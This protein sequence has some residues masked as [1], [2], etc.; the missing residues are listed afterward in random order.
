MNP[1]QKLLSFWKRTSPEIPQYDHSIHGDL[2][3][4]ELPEGFNEI[5]RYWIKEPYIFVYILNNTRT[6]EMVYYV[7]EPALSPYEIILLEKLHEDLMDILTEKEA[8]YEN[9]HKKYKLKE[10][11]IELLKQY[12][13]SLK[14]QTIYKIVYYLNRNL[15]GY[16]KIDALLND[17]QIEDISCDGT[18]IPIFLYHRKHG[19]IKTNILFDE[20]EL[21]SFVIK[22]CQKGGKHISLGSP[23]VNATLPNGSRLQ[24]TLGRD[25]TTR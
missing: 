11:A 22:I 14:E 1:V 23:L 20:I 19:N 5:E 10:Y 9:V 6:K 4:S 24:A 12:S 21:N 18:G 17:P 8:L 15:L 25:I 16:E 7:V 2:V 3:L 13:K